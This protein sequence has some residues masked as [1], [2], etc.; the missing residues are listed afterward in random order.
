MP[1]VILGSN[2]TNMGIFATASMHSADAV[3]AARTT[4][5]GHHSN[6]SRGV[7]GLAPPPCD[8]NKESTVVCGRNYL[9]R[10]ATSHQPPSGA[11]RSEQKGG[12]ERML[13]M[14]G[15]MLVHHKCKI[16]AH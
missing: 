13:T 1:K 6:Y 9:T 16:Y 7:F 2:E 14:L 15:E 4:D 11:H 12:W 3:H 5:Y 8:S 10:R